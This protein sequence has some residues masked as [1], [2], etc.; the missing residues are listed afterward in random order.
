MLNLQLLVH[1]LPCRAGS[2]VAGPSKKKRNQDQGGDF[3]GKKEKK[4][5]KK[6]KKKHRKDESED[7][8]DIVPD[9]SDM[10]EGERSDYLAALEMSLQVRS[11]GL[12][13]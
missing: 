13:L 8:S 3:V 9:D 6:K 11:K 1:L 4:K 2:P 5:K 12:N 7:S 10:S